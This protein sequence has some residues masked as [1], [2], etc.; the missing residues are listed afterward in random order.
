MMKDLEREVQMK[1][2]KILEF[3][4]RFDAVTQNLLNKE[5]NLHDTRVEK[6]KIEA[7]YQQF[8]DLMIKEGKFL[9]A[10]EEE[11]EENATQAK[12]RWNK[13]REEEEKSFVDANEHVRVLKELKEL[14]ASKDLVQQELEKYKE[15]ARELSVT[16]N[17]LQVKNEN[18]TR[19]A[20]TNQSIIE[21]LK[22]QKIEIE[23]KG[24]KIIQGLEIRYQKEINLSE[25]RVE[26]CMARILRDHKKMVGIGRERYRSQLLTYLIR[27]IRSYKRKISR[28][29]CYSSIT[30]FLRQRY[31][32]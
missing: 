16:N 30:Q 12:H 10:V 6:E 26:D 4:E 28:L 21:Q 15:R 32:D 7:E 13:Q 17:E 20:K 9:A 31:R 24:Q 23:Y 5:K 2:D 19:E 14:Q 18:F 29:T 3:R 22:T 8:K 25:M 1:E 27:K 11:R